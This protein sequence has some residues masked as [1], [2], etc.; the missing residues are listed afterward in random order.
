MVIAD[1]Y[2]YYEKLHIEFFLSN[3]YGVSNW[4]VLLFV[5]LSLF[6]DMRWLNTLYIIRRL[7]VDTPTE[8]EL[9]FDYYSNRVQSIH[10]QTNE[11]QSHF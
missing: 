9:R 2:S 1:K 4:N 11:F 5:R 10:L 7:K 3:V 6:K 8:V